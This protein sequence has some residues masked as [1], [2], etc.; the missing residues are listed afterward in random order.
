MAERDDAS[1]RDLI[2]TAM[3]APLLLQ[4]G[5]L[6]PA[7][8]ERTRCAL[9]SGALQ[10]IA[11][12]SWF[13]DDAGV[14]F[15]I[16]KAENLVRKD[17]A[18]RQR[19]HDDDAPRNPFLPCEQALVVAP[20]SPSHVA[21]L[22]KFNVIDHHLLIV[23]RRF[24]HQET[25]LTPDDFIALAA[26]LREFDALAFYNAGPAAGASQSHKHLQLVPL[27]LGGGTDGVPIESLLDAVRGEGGVR[28]VPGFA[29]RHA[30]ARLD[31]RSPVDAMAT[32]DVLRTLYRALLA[33]AGLRGIDTNGEERQ[34][35]PYNLLVTRRWMLL[36]PRSRECFG[37]LSINALGYA[38]SLFVRDEAEFET[39][40][41]AGP[42]SVL[43]EVA[44]R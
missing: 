3:P 21:V 26:C 39:L 24:E 29:F 4:P 19:Q 32:A 12:E 38:G 27:P 25:L 20:I 5:T 11:A 10:P 34:S 35:A 6:W 13:I 36:V 17:T 40:R 2:A 18:R 15:A 28:T 31:E 7:T 44:V 42:L 16:R 9:A 41:R 30:F 1:H 37:T 33:A 14:R 22:N 8:V 23:T 43:R